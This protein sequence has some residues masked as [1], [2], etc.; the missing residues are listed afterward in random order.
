MLQY[1]LPFF[2]RF[3]ISHHF[4]CVSVHCWLLLYVIIYAFGG[5]LV[6][7]E[8]EYEASKFHWNEQIDKKNLC[9]VKILRKLKDYSDETVKHLERCWKADID[10]TKEWNY[11]TSTLYGFGTITTLGCNHVAP[12]TIAGRLFSIIYGILVS[13]RHL[14]TLIASWRRK[15]ETFQ[16]RNW[17]REVNLENN[18]DREKEKNEEASSGYVTIIIIGTFLLMYYSIDFIN[19]LYYNFLCLAAIDFGQLIPERIALLPITF[20]YVCVGLALATIA[21]VKLICSFDSF[22]CWCKICQKL[23]YFGQRIKNVAATKIWFGSK[24]LRVQEVLH[25]VGSK[26]GIEPSVIDEI[27]LDN[28]IEET[29]VQ[30]EGRLPSPFTDEENP[31][32]PSSTT[33][34]SPNKS[35]SSIEE[36]FKMNQCFAIED[37]ISTIS[38]EETFDIQNDEKTI[39]IEIIQYDEISEA[40]IFV[41]IETMALLKIMNEPSKYMAV[42]ETVNS[43]NDSKESTK[44]I[45]MLRKFKERKKLYARDP[46]N[47]HKVYEKEWKRIENLIRDRR[48][49]TLLQYSSTT[50]TQL[51]SKKL[52]SFNSRENYRSRSNLENKKN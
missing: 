39:A 6:F 21:I 15:L 29:I 45:K 2:N 11:I 36:L 44:E 12:S 43:I 18:K 38:S 31:L 22:R 47:L 48:R 40:T 20:V 41:Q 33:T 51:S 14:N 16:V 32:S 5:G 26:C 23:Q 17:N 37:T 27:D 1:L 50:A 3:L 10:K 34:K 4:R 30:N 9:I 52:Q 19:G 25:A 7:Y 13:G 35:P 46:Q 28:L 8:L 42:V 24:T 49:K